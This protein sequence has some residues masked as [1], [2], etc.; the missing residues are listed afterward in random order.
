MK[1]KNLVIVGLVYLVLA[2]AGG[3]SFAEQYW[4]AAKALPVNGKVILI[5]AGH[6]G[7]DPGKTGTMK[8]EKDLN[9]II[10]KQLQAYLEMG[11]ASVLMTRTE[12]EMLKKS[13]TATK[14]EDMQ[15]R[16]EMIRQYDPDLVISIHQNSFPDGKYWGPQVFYWEANDEGQQLALLIQEQ[17][18]IFTGGKRQCKANGDYYI[19]KQSE[20]TAVLVECG[21]LTNTAEEARLND[22]TYQKKIA[23]SIYSGINAYFEEEE[24][25]NTVDTHGGS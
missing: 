14:K 13:E 4:A 8:D 15:L 1:I 11:G 21:F 16:G 3:Q 5:D 20:K 7:A 22:E 23:W 18:N 24:H 19:L 17:L 12:D 9:L 2:T 6:G 10:A 25:G